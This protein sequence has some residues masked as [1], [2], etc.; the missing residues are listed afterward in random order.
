MCPWPTLIIQKGLKYTDGSKRQLGSIITQNNRP[1]AFFSRKISVCHQK[2]SVIEIELLVI[3]ETLKEF[4]GM[5][6]GQ[7]I[8]VYTDHKNLM[9]DVLGLTCERLAFI[10]R[11]IWSGNRAQQG[12][13]QDSCGYD[14]TL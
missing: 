7:A 3:V 5:L 4:K 6:W 11:G 1:I 12:N 9:Q 2:Y 10:A 14:L 8:V 13:P